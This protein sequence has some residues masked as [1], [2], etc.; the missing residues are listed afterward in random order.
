MQ[1]TCQLYQ[2]SEHQYLLTKN[3]AQYYATN[4][5]DIEIK[6]DNENRVNWLNY[7]SINY[8]EEIELLAEI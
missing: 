2:Y 8:R 1:H 5:V 7:H 4:F 3:S 6:K